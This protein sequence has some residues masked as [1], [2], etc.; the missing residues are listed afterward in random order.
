MYSNSHHANN[1]WGNT[2]N[3][4]LFLTTCPHFKDDNPEFGEILEIMRNGADR[5]K[6]NTRLIGIHGL[7]FANAL[8][9]TYMAPKNNYIDAY[10]TTVPEISVAIATKDT[11][12]PDPSFLFNHT[13]KSNGEAHY[14]TLS[15]K[16]G[17]TALM[18]RETPGG[19]DVM[20]YSSGGNHSLGRP[21]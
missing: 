19:D 9:K 10:V 16:W 12:P 17:I 13:K 2:I 20:K 8:M 14:A 6:I 7:Q 1:W 5:M 11:T 15:G 18:D 3:V 21:S 4:P